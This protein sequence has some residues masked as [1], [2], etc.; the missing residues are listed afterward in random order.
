MMDAVQAAE[1]AASAIGRCHHLAQYSEDE[2][3]ITRRFLSPPQLEV[4]REVRAWM[5]A[6]G[7]A[8]RIDAA[9]NLI[10]R[11]AGSA[12][13]G[14]PALLIGSHLDT[15][16]DAGRFDGILGVMA[17]IAMV[18][19]FRHEH[20][21]FPIEIIGFS[22]EEGV[23]FRAPYIGSYAVAGT[24]DP[25]LLQLRDRHGVTLEEVLREQ[26]LPPEGIPF[27]AHKPE[28]VLAFLELHIEQGPVLER[29]EHRIGIVESIVGQD[30]LTVVFTG[31]A[32]HAGTTPMDLRQDAGVAAARWIVAVAE[33]AAKTEGVRAT[34]G[35]AHFLPGAGN[36]IPGRVVAS[37]D[38]RHRNDQVRLRVREELL[39][40]AT[41]IAE[42]AGCTFE[43]TEATS[44]N[45]VPMDPALCD[46]LEGEAHRLEL[47]TLRMS[48]GAGHDSAVMARRFP[49]G[50]MFIP[51]PGGIS[52]H[53]DE[54]VRT[55]DVAAA[56]RV[57]AG[58][59]G[60]LAASQQN[61]QLHA[62]AV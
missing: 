46:L 33:F 7:M 29:R 17:G 36:V 30:R 41:R 27:A 15:V 62:P 32:G 19:H 39:S 50:L 42:A 20:L 51:S 35:R 58:T 60:R 52:H 21:P 23:R 43:V 2:G 3:R 31:H 45:A 61:A 22:E 48:S 1:A 4:Y 56:L 9:G 34:V 13:P 53:P 49:T 5:E 8:V 57:M 37:F 18:E 10:G 28:E 14:A 55:D 47:S 16:P 54:A 6:A 24:F 26:G 59:I 12:P 38:L 25:A 40:A 11:F 44:H